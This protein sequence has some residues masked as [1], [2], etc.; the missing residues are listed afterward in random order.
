MKQIASLICIEDIKNESNGISHKE[1]WGAAHDIGLTISLLYKSETTILPFE[2]GQQLDFI[3]TM[4]IH[5]TGDGEAKQ[6]VS[7]TSPL[8]T[9][10]Q[11][12]FFCGMECQLPVSIAL[13]PLNRTSVIMIQLCI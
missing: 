7:F 1:S 8:M 11:I 5:Q 12:L 3:A 2:V 4:V 9:H 10:T 6:K 13:E